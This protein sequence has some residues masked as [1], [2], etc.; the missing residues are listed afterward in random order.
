[1]ALKFI[2]KVG[3][4]EK[5]LKNLQREID[6]MRNLEHE[7]IIKLL[8]SFETPKEVCYIILRST[9]YDDKRLKSAYKSSGPLGWQLPLVSIQH[10]VT[11]GISTPPWKGC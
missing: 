8:D 11:R 1:V 4:S 10:E 2:P 9:I 3:R 7:N 6:I 5:E